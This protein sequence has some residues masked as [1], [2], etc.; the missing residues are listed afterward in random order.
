M[1]YIPACNTV[2]CFNEDV[3]PFYQPIEDFQAGIDCEKLFWKVAVQLQ[4]FCFLNPL[5]TN[6]AQHI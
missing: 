1:Y 2:S 6:I 3:S 5:T 4:E